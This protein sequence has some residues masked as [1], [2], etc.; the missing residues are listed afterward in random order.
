MPKLT[1][2]VDP[3]VVA[4]A[5][6]YARRH[7]VSVSKLVEV[8]LGGLAKPQAS[9]DEPPVLRSLRGTMKSADV[10]DYHKHLRAKHR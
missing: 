5:K 8:Y 9:E 3:S 6:R 7:G 10:R 1:L 2:S 4:G